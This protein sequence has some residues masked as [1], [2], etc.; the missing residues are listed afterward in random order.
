VDQIFTKY[1]H[2]AKPFDR[3]SQAKRGVFPPMFEELG[4]MEKDIARTQGTAG[5]ADWFEDLRL[6]GHSV[7]MPLLYD[8]V[9]RLEP[10][11]LA[12]RY[13]LAA[14][15]DKVIFGI[16]HKPL[17]VSCRARRLPGLR[18]I[19]AQASERLRTARTGDRATLPWTGSRHASGPRSSAKYGNRNICDALD[20]LRWPVRL[21]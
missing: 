11:D 18:D 19:G 1:I 9:I 2:N 20:H 3:K 15:R 12:L 7:R 4:S 10:G 16:A 14:G 8:W 17:M 6:A 13:M 5:P 21:R